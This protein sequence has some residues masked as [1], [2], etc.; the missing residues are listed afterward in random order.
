MPQNTKVTQ[1]ID[2]AYA[3]RVQSLT[4]NSLHKLK[5]ISHL[6]TSHYVQRTIT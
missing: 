5:N 4:K 6:Q 1:Y 3:H 2:R